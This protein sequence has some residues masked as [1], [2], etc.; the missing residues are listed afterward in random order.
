MLSKVLSLIL[1][2]SNFIFIIWN[3]SIICSQST[4]K[5]KIVLRIYSTQK[6]DILQHQSSI[7]IAILILNCFSL[8][9]RFEKKWSFSI[10]GVFKCNF[11]VAVLPFQKQSFPTITGHSVFSAD[12]LR[13]SSFY[14]SKAKIE[15]D[16]FFIR[17][18]SFNLRLSFL[19]RFFHRKRS[20]W[21]SS[22]HFLNLK[23]FLFN[24]SISSFLF[25]GNLKNI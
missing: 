23:L 21:S 2:Y 19:T 11:L 10:S 4:D 7:G 3:N 8:I 14:K 6:P 12:S 16:K 5:Q 24:F 20:K 22:K 15:T 18:S 9:C 25:G 17:T 13:S 1:F